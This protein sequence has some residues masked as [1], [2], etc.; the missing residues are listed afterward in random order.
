[1]TFPQSFDPLIYDIILVILM[2]TLIS[3]AASAR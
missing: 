2:Q 1:M 3:A